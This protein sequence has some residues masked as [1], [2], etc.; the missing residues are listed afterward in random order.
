MAIAR[1][2]G[3][4]QNQK[5]TKLQNVNYECKSELL[6]SEVTVA[7]KRKRNSEEIKICE[8]EVTFDVP[9]WAF[10][11]D[12]RKSKDNN[13]LV[14][15]L[16][17]FEKSEPIEKSFVYSLKDNA[18]NYLLQMA[19]KFENFREHEN[20]TDLI[21]CSAVVV[22]SKNKNFLNLKIEKEISLQELDRHII[23]LEKKEAENEEAQEDDE[24]EEDD[25][26]EE[27][28]DE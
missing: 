12:F 13:Y 24:T 2:N 6:F 3:F 27:S 23:R 28:E 20:F 9:Q 5:N 14:I 21:G 17:I 10:I 7:K 15:E 22:I 11:K 26:D 18:V 16:L 8:K 4:K 1:K 25:E 19:R